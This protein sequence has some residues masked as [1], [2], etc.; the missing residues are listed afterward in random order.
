[1]KFA[2]CLL[3]TGVNFECS[4][5]NGRSEN[6]LCLWPG[7]SSLSKQASTTR[8]C[9]SPQQAYLLGRDGSETHSHR[10]HSIKA[11]ESSRDNRKLNLGSVSESTSVSVT[12]PNFVA[13]SKS[14]SLHI[15]TKRVGGLV[16][17]RLKALLHQCVCELLA[18]A[19]MR[20][21]LLVAIPALLP[22]SQPLLTHAALPRAPC[23][24]PGQTVQIT[25]GS[26]FPIF[27]IYDC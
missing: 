16:G 17:S 1:M 10:T 20:V 23:Q 26:V 15:M 6:S 19:A 24:P 25:A 2:G 9:T 22:R 4:Q 13:R 18:G 11:F 12:S 7:L 21:L 5:Y 27:Q 8:W 14:G 3:W